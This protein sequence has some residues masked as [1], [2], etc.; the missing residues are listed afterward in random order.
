MKNPLEYLHCCSICSVINVL[1]TTNVL[2]P[3]ASYGSVVKYAKLNI[4][5]SFALLEYKI[6]YKLQNIT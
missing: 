2:M 4:Q 6:K 1:Q 3:Q 5:I